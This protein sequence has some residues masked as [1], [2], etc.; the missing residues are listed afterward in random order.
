[1]NIFSEFHFAYNTACHTN[2]NTT[3]AFQNLGRDPKPI[4]SLRIQEDGEPVKLWK[5]R[6]T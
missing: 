6:M 1:M 4:N 5:E 2:S 3:P